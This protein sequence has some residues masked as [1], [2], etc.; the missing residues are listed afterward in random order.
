M[1]YKFPCGETAETKVDVGH[2]L[3]MLIAQ[4]DENG[5]RWA[6]KCEECTLNCTKEHHA[7]YLNTKTNKETRKIDTICVGYSEEYLTN[8]DKPTLTDLC[9]D[10]YEGEYTIEVIIQIDEYRRIL[11][12]KGKSENCS[13]LDLADAFNISDALENEF[14]E[15][16]YGYYLLW[17]TSLETGQTTTIEFENIYRIMDKIVSVRFVE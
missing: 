12:I 11:Y 14:I 16:G 5:K 2:A 17:M 10:G 15:D 3:G 9:E 13:L 4:E 8:K 7:N 1:I 6:N